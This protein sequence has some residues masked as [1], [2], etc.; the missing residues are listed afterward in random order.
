MQEDHNQPLPPE[1]DWNNMKAGIFD[2]MQ[3]I[4][5]AESAQRNNKHAWKRIGL[6]LS[7]FFALA[8]GLFSVFQHR[9][10]DQHP[11]AQEVVRLPETDRPENRSDKDSQSVL[12]DQTE[13]PDEVPAEKNGK[14]QANGLLLTYKESAP[15]QDPKKSESAPIAIDQLPAYQQPDENGPLNNFLET[16]RIEAAQ[17]TLD[18]VQKAFRTLTTETRLPHL[19]L[20]SPAL[21]ALPTDGLDPMRLETKRHSLPDIQ[22]MDS[23]SRPGMR[24]AKSPD[25]LIVE[26]GITFW[27]EGY[28]NSKPERAQYEAPLPSFQLQGHYLKSFKGNYFIMAGLQYQQLE[29][30]LIYNTIIPDYK[31][32]LTDTIIQVQNNLLT[33]EQ[34]IIRG[35]VEQSVQAEHRVRHYN[36]TQLFKTSVAVGKNWRFRSF[37]TDVYL[38][39]ALNSVVHSQGRTFYENTIIDYKG[40]S[41]SVFQN[42]WTAEGV[43]G[44]RL[45]YFLS[46]NLGVTT[47]VQA[48]K[49][50]MNWS[51]PGD[52]NFYPASVSLQLGLSY[53]L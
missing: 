43:L 5:Q 29:S 37:Q 52:M 45:H 26:A 51:K 11:V 13:C 2:K 17:S 14:T 8:I 40:A 12:A 49:S 35:D 50:L 30:K 15:H 24:R 19:V 25:Q 46:P 4:D 42:Q 3:S 7:L 21:Q 48:Q 9:I 34:T 32:T 22:K 36:K 23:V 38:G 41:N 39:G 53:S 31:I 18:T 1:L 10:T 6:F 44:L 16:D 20:H 47:G 33:G 28:G 27:K